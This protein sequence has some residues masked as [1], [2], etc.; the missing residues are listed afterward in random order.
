MGD[1][2]HVGGAVIPITVFSWDEDEL[3][4]IYKPRIE[5]IDAWRLGEAINSFYS[6]SK[7]FRPPIINLT[8]YPA[9]QFIEK[10]RELSRLFV[11]SSASAYTVYLAKLGFNLDEIEKILGSRKRF[12]AL[13][14]DLPFLVI[15]HDYG[16][17]KS[18]VESMPEDLRFPLPDLSAKSIL[19]ERAGEN[20]RRVIN[21]T[22]AKRID[23]VF[24][25]I[26]GAI[27]L[28]NVPRWF[29]S[30]RHIDTGGV[31]I[32]RSIL[33]RTYGVKRTFLLPSV[34]VLV[35][36]FSDERE[37]RDFLELITGHAV[38]ALEETGDKMLRE[39]DRWLIY[40]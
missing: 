13:L 7:I 1:N 3:S 39:P 26:S 6:F 31:D 20:G 2:V 29:E 19:I 15:G 28:E 40:I 35:P 5:P 16:V 33:E 11:N 4:K 27:L 18:N 30:A 10:P 17:L 36:H 25:V 21:A 12:D 34:A 38:K 22:G 9:T 37:A 8:L 23:L 32:I 14:G 24:M